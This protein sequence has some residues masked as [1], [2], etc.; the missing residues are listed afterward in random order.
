MR[1]AAV[2]LP[3]GTSTKAEGTDSVRLADAV[4]ARL[5][6]V[7]PTVKLPAAAGVP[8]MMPVV[9][10]NVSPAGRAVEFPNT[11]GR[12]SPFVALREKLN[13]ISWWAVAARLPVNAGSGTSEPMAKVI[14]ALPVPPGF[15]AK[16]VT[17]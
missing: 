12:V 7:T 2:E 1:K 16:R 14:V 10:F 17:G 5:E 15:V 11:S 9:E 4:P 3:A 13:G 6:A 8:E